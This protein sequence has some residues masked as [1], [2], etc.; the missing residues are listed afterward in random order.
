MNTGE[1][2]N[3]LLQNIS[4][5]NAEEATYWCRILLN[6]AGR[7]GDELKGI[8]IDQLIKGFGLGEDDL[9]VLLA[10]LV[11]I[12]VKDED[13][14]VLLERFGAALEEGLKADSSFPIL[15]TLC[16]E[17]V[18]KIG[19]V[20]GH[21]VPESLKIACLKCL[22]SDNPRLSAKVIE[23]LR[24][25]KTEFIENLLLAFSRPNDPVSQFRFMEALQ[26][27]GQGSESQKLLQFFLHELKSLLSSSADPLLLANALH[28]VSDCVQSREAFVVMQQNGIIEL[29]DGLLSAPNGGMVS[30]IV[31]FFGQCAFN[32]CLSTE[33]AV[34]LASKLRGLLENEDTNVKSSVIFTLCAFA[35][36]DTL[37]D[38]V[39]STMPEVFSGLVHGHSSTQLA[40]LH[41]LGLVFKQDELTPAKSSLLLQLNSYTSEPI[42]T[43]LTKRALSN[44]DE[45][46]GAAYFCLQG[47]LSSF[48]GVKLALDTSS[49]MA[50]L[51]N[52]DLDDSAL[53]SKWK[54]G[55]LEMVA[56]KTHLFELLN[57][58]LREQVLRY[59]GQGVIFKA[60]STRVAF[61]ASQ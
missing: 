46:K 21:N 33:E 8:P 27:V 17:I 10:E 53:G 19:L 38:T 51:L 50:D 26:A 44:F 34:Y 25:V 56:K 18:M 24:G 6:R 11:M 20:N 4:E 49:I 55:I 31:D 58:P 9:S 1:V 2:I 28:T 37:F 59:L 7:D 12:I 54:Y 39:S 15:Q 40:A 14:P 3:Q 13:F 57:A 16:L 45:Q 41:G 30:R 35:S 61:E 60:V 47:L 48:Q 42:Y 32:D 29:L 22:F 5:L 43:W 36:K 52:R 23:L